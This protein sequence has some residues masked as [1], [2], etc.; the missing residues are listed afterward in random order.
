MKTVIEHIEEEI[1][2]EA[3]IAQEES[4][5]GGMILFGGFDNNT[6]SYGLDGQ[7]FQTGK[8]IGLELAILILKKWF[9]K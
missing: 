7:S 1:N 6:L 8:K 9:D 3:L 4:E 2:K 5:L